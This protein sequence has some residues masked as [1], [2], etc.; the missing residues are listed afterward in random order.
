MIRSGNFYTLHERRTLMRNKYFFS[1]GHVR[2]QSAVSTFY[3]HL[4]SSPAL[5]SVVFPF[6]NATRGDGAF[7]QA[8][9][10]LQDK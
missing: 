2:N 10:G 5:Y 4:Y 6:Q 1:V 7:F 8:N 3:W 9:L